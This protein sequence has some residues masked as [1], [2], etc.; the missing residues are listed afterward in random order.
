MSERTTPRNPAEAGFSLP[1]LM[2]AMLVTLALMAIVFTIMRQNQALFATET[3]VTSMNENM[4][5]AV[6]LITREVQAAGTGL[7][8]MSAP[9]LGVDGEGDASD[10]LVLLLGDPA[11]PIAQVRSNSP[12]ASGTAL[13]A[14]IPPPGTSGPANAPQYRDDRGKTQS[15]YQPGDRY[16]LYND[17]R[18]LVVRIASTSVTSGGDILVSCVADKSNPKPKFGD[19]RSRP[20]AD[21]NGALFA[22]LDTI[23]TYRFDREAETLERR[24]TDDG[25]AAVA[26][27][28]IGFQ[29]RYRVLNADDTLS[30][31][32]DDP[33]TERDTVRSVV[34]T[35]RARTVDADPGTANYRETAE[36]IE[37]TPRNMRLQWPAGQDAGPPS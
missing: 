8:G 19:Y 18:F 31:P 16:V 36:R 11:A 33:P 34:V 9:I 17:S 25:F 23:V 22:K 2:L 10:R 26:N 37:I 29:T 24:D 15:L 30:E 6:D 14:L 20:G 28:I 13:I 12:Y 27:G 3:G 4:R 5:A 21:S 32:K 7:R 1:E 35:I